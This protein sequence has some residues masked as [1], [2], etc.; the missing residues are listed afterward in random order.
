MIHHLHGQFGLD[1]AGP[2]WHLGVSF[3]FVLSGFILT[4]VHSDLRDAAAARHFYVARFARIWPLH[5]ATLV[6]AALFLAPAYT[7]RGV[8]PFI[9]NALLLQ[10]WW[11]SLA[12]NFSYNWLAWT[13][14]NEAFFYVLFPLVMIARR[15]FGAIF[16]A[17]IALLLLAFLVGGNLEPKPPPPTATNVASW[18]VWIMTG[19]PVR[20]FEFIFGMGVG[21]VYLRY[22]DVQM[23]AW[24]WSLAEVLAIA[25]ILAYAITTTAFLDLVTP[26]LGPVF[27]RWYQHAGGFLVFGFAILCFA[28]SNGLLSR[29]LSLPLLVLLGEISFSTYMI[30]Q[31]VIRAWGRVSGL[32]P[33]STAFNVVALLLVIYVGSYLTWRFLERP[34]QRAILSFA[35]SRRELAPR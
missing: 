14:S 7:D 16:V 4:Y 31:L 25:A 20:F 28:Y 3:F 2:P 30:H 29:A 9:V 35:R 18:Y 15:N 11:P 5:A 1:L 34:A 26:A 12:S 8:V 13:I 6:F 22:R 33:E 24:A 17:T 32:M 23:P 10:A 21:F 19:P 27:R